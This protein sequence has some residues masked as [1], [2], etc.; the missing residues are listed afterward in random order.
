[1]T[2]AR[3]S[4]WSPVHC[5]RHTQ[6]WRNDD[7]VESL[8]VTH[9]PL[10][11]HGHVTTSSVDSITYSRRH[12]LLQLNALLSLVYHSSTLECLKCADISLDKDGSVRRK[13]SVWLKPRECLCLWPASIISDGHACFQLV[14]YTRDA[15]HPSGV[16]KWGVGWFIDGLSRWRHL[17][18]AY[19]VTAAGAVY[20][21]AYR[22]LCWQLMPVLNLVVVG[23]TWPACQ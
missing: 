20:V 23:C 14:R 18:N 21:T 19:E 3:V 6:L 13:R 2:G 4:Q 11:W 5:G 1:M 22:R 17:V 12:G 7:V 15:F 9:V 16:D 10:L 8:S